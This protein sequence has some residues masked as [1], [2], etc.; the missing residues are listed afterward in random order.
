TSSFS[1]GTLLYMSPEQVMNKPV[2]AQSDIFSLGVVAYEALTK[3]HPFRGTTEEEIVEAIR[4]L[5]PPPAS[6][7]ND[8]V[9]QLISRV[10]HKAIAKQPLNRYDSAREFGENLQ[11]AQHNQPIEIFD[12]ARF[13]PRIDRARKAVAGGDYQFAGEIIGELEA[14]GHID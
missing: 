14:S 6:G 3:R 4:R 8:T 13:Q 2:T 10:V 5:N 11:R 12:P 1:K 7:L 9:S